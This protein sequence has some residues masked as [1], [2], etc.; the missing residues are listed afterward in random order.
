MEIADR[1]NISTACKNAM[2]EMLSTMQ[3]PDFKKHTK[4]PKVRKSIKDFENATTDLQRLIE[5]SN[6]PEK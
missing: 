6:L 2:T 1:K 3:D 5:I 4:D